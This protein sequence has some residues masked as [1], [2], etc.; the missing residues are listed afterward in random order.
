M[1]RPISPLRQRMI[2]DMKF[3]N[4][5]P[6]TYFGRVP[7]S[8]EMNSGTVRP[9]CAMMPRNVPRCGTNDSSL[10]INSMNFIARSAFLAPAATTMTQL[11][12][13]ELRATDR[14]SP[15][16]EVDAQACCLSG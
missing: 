5:S 15:D 12:P 16:I 11:A 2:D 4:M 8:S 6:N 7:Y 10:Q 9:A 3:P 13:R 1:S 14:V